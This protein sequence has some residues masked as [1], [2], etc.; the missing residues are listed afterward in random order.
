MRTVVAFII[1]SYHPQMD[2]FRRLLTLLRAYP[3]IVVDNGGTLT[4]DDVRKA[5]LLS[6]TS[7]LGYGAASNIGIRHAAGLGA[8]WF[9][10]L[11]QDIEFTK[12]SVLLFVKQL[13][14]LSPCIAGPFAAAL[15]DSRWTT[16]L[17]SEK[18]GYITGSCLAIHE[19]VVRK[20]G[21]FYEPYFLYYED[22]D[23]C[24][25]ARRANIPLVRVPQDEVGHAETASLGKGS[26]AH[27]YYLARNHLLF[28]ARQAP[29]AV[30][31]YELLRLPLTVGE[32]VTRNERGALSG[33]RD[34]IV[35]RFGKYP[36]R[37]P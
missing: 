19:R 10:I 36:G 28:V 23:Y 6:Q 31:L 27:Q 14:K 13:K 5:T 7:N 17:P 4:F 30:K 21:Y 35:R 26:E 2:R 1:V 22:A 32:H 29:T 15:D 33:I 9:V 16:I 8:K 12:Q 11:N 34:F 24:V 37:T 3:V 25:R 20:I 18:V